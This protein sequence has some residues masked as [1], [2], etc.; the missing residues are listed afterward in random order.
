MKGKGG[1]VR[2]GG[3]SIQLLI[4]ERRLSLREDNAKRGWN[5]A[6]DTAGDRIQASIIDIERQRKKLKCKRHSNVLGKLWL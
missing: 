2:Q 6:L 1:T 3:R 4:I 5:H